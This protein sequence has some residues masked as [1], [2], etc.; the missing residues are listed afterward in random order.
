MK[1][2]KTSLDLL[3]WDGESADENNEP[4]DGPEDSDTPVNENTPASENTPANENSNSDCPAPLPG[5][6]GIKINPSDIPK[7]HT[8]A[9]LPSTTGLLM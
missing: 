9:W 1:Q 8:T 2:R 6:K 5:Y 4:R 7:L 3:G